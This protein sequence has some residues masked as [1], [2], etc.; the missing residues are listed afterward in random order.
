MNEEERITQL[1]RGT[2]WQGSFT[3]QTSPLPITRPFRI[4]FLSEL[5]ADGALLYFHRLMGDV[6]AGIEDKAC[7]F[8]PR[9]LKLET[10]SVPNSAVGTIFVFECAKSEAEESKLANSRTAKKTL[11]NVKIFIEPDG[12]LK[13]IAHI[14]VA[15]VTYQLTRQAIP[16][17]NV[18]LRSWLESP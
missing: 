17:T 1:L 13:I 10:S 11:K 15:D 8:T 12:A 3:A 7:E 5:S 9:A 14:A 6:P 2:A 16:P 18:A 4:V